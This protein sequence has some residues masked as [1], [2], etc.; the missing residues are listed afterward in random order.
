MSDPARPQSRFRFTTDLL[1]FDRASSYSL[2]HVRTPLPH[3]LSICH[4]IA[5]PARHPRTDIPRFR[6]TTD[7]LIFDRASSYS[8]P[9][10]RTPLPHDLSICHSIATPARHPRTD[11]P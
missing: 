9:H 4:S 8:L 6:F 3:D 10:V 2:P 1:I 11:I 5:T 7:L